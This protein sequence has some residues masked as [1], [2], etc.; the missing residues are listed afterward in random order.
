[1]AWAPPGS[2]ACPSSAP[3]VDVSGRWVLNRVEGD[4]DGLMAD[5]G[6]SWATRRLAKSFNYGAGLV[7]QTIEQEGDSVVIVFQNGPG[8]AAHTMRLSVGGGRQSTD[9]ED[10]TRVA[11]EPVWQDKSLLIPGQ[12]ADGSTMQTTRRFLSGQEMV[13]ES[14]TSKGCVVR[15]YFARG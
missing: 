10:G 13:C 14:L 3:P 4:F 5:A 15:R 12:N 1:V 6:V 2:A 11:I 7:S 9:N 8:Q